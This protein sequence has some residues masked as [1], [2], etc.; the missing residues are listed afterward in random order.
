MTDQSPVETVH[1]KAVDPAINALFV[2]A[3]KAQGL[4][5]VSGVTAAPTYHDHPHRPEDFDSIPPDAESQA[6][7]TYQHLHEALLAGGAR[8]TTVVMLTRFLTD[9]ENDQ[10][11]VNRV[12]NEFFGDYL[13]TSTTVEIR[14]LATDPRLRLEVQ[15]IAALDSGTG[16]S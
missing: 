16:A 12:Q 14:R 5:F 11:A 1:T 6:R 7:L 8:P 2:P 15:A 4:L 9:V 3:I 13:P 10:D